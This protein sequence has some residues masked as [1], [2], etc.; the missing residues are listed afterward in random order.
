V[1]RLEK[2]AGIA[3]HQQKEFNKYTYKN[4]SFV[5]ADETT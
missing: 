2:F 1:T 5:F 3:T 4:K